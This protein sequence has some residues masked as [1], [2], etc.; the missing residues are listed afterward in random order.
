MRRGRRGQFLEASFKETNQ[1]LPMKRPKFIPLHPTLPGFAGVVGID[2]AKREF[3]AC[4]LAH[5]QAKP[6]RGTFA[7]TVDGIAKFLEWLQ[8]VGQGQNL[9]LCMEDTGIYSLNLANV[10]HEH[11][12]YMSLVNPGIIKKYGESQNSRTKNDAADALIIA[13]FA[14]ERHPAQWQPLAS[15]HQKL[16]SLARRREQLKES[17]LQ[18]K[19]R[20]EACLDPELGEEI[21][22]SIA[23]FD[24]QIAQKWA[25]MKALVAADPVLRHNS[26][27]LQS[28]PGIGPLTASMLL[29][30]LP[31]L[32]NFGSGRS[33]CA[34]AGLS[35][36]Q[37]DSG[38]RK[39][40]TR[41]CKQGRAGLRRIL[42]MP[43]MSLL[44]CKAGPLKRFADRLL[45]KSKHA[46]CVIGALMRKLLA[47][48]FA[49]LRSG[50]MFNPDYRR[51]T[52]KIA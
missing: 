20:L 11:K 13:L 36:R 30:E 28:I 26:R 35:P 49:I 5:A 6:K 50:E 29:A 51:T 19:N 27:L 9:H 41:L 15:K 33:L 12:L 1:L 52:A 39:G 14:L 2:V 21:K 48:V 18:E 25:E 8:R 46:M 4:F 38:P 16:R 43:A 34:Y 31:P 22:Q 44:S 24:E 32:E 45:S 40:R 10:L 42:Y 47:V 23:R 17:R 37:N 3:V 7:M